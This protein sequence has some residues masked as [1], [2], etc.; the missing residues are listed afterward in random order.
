MNTH[1]ANRYTQFITPLGGIIALSCFFLPWVVR[2]G[3][4]PLIEK[5][6]SLTY[7]MSGFRLFLP[8]SNLMHQHAIFI[9]VVF[10]ASLL[11]VG[12]SLYMVI[13]RTPWKS[14]APILISGNIGLAILFA[15][16]LRYARMTQ[17]TEVIEHSST[18]AMKL[19]F[20]GTAAGL[21]IA[22]IGILFVRAEKE[23][24]DSKGSVAEKQRWFVVHAGGIIALFCFFMPWQG[25]GTLKG[26]SGFQLIRM[27][28]IIVIAFIA[29]VITL[30][31]SFYT[32]ASENL[33]RLRE[34]VLVSIGI[35]LGL[36]LTYCV[37]FYIQE[38]HLQ[39][40][41]RESN[42]EIPTPSVRF[43]LW[44]TILGYIV[45]AVGMFLTRRK[46]KD[47]QIEVVVA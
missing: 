36:I 27:E 10:I 20:W 47:K 25:F 2:S 35:G 14:R 33:R 24:R 3:A 18:Y 38:I 44:G 11:I 28:P 19:G 4:P 9:A 12:L 29:S 34:M 26:S 13:R 42:T 32:L 23:S 21:V 46:N 30:I 41:L 39:A 43:G 37:T 22:V 6:G 7:G 8:F 16:Q 40:L 1:Q 5:D 45:A 15:E 31:G 17:M